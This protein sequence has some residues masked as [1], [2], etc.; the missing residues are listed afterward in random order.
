MNGHVQLKVIGFAVA[1]VALIVVACG[2]EPKPEPTAPTATT[3]PPPPLPPTAPPPDALATSSAH[4][5]GAPGK[6][7]KQ[8][9]CDALIDDANST[10]DADR[11]E[12]DKL[13]KKDADCMPIMGRACNFNCFN[14]AIPKSE[15]KSWNG[16]VSKVKDGACKKWTDNDC[17]KQ[18]TKPPPTCQD[19]KISCDKGHCAA[20]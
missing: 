15:E 18:R 14:G 8:A 2:S 13:C 1:S 17:A 19:K 3:P 4:D 6:S 10:L 7:D 11:I 9:E 5:G 12:M 16:A 20:K